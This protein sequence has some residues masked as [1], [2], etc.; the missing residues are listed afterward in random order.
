MSRV[1]KRRRFAFDSNTRP[2]RDREFDAVVVA[3]TGILLAVAF[4]M[5]LQD[6][7]DDSQANNQV[8]SEKVA[9]DDAE[10]P[11]PEDLFAPHPA[12]P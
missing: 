8:V 7:E 10:H 2:E 11:G 4:W 12:S 1:R 9:L 5:H 6:R 3:T